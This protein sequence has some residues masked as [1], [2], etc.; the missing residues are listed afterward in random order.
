MS[1]LDSVI[2][3]RREQ[4]FNHDLWQLLKSG[5]I[6]PEFYGQYLWQQRLR[7][8]R[9]IEYA[10]EMG[11][12]KEFPE[13]DR[14]HLIRDDFEEIW[15]KQLGKKRMPYQPAMATT[16]F[17]KHLK[18]IFEDEEEDSMQVLAYMYVLYI[19]DMNG[20]DKLA[21]AVP[22]AGRHYKFNGDL[23]NLKERIKAKL[24]DTMI[25]EINTCFDSTIELYNEIWQW[26][27]PKF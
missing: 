9:M 24:N 27:I 13:L 8:E 17:M 25:D 20:G 22:G 21:S 12:L 2:D 18:E 14:Y 11:L 6:N 15:K 1:K 4:L 7:Y 26:T 23:E 16:L 19:M 10:E 5:K 3:T